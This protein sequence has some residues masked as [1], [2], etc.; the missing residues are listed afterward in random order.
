M[1][2]IYHSLLSM[3]TADGPGVRYVVFLQGCPLRCIYCHNPDTWEVDGGISISVDGLVA[4]ILSVREYLSGGVTISGGEPLLQAKFVTE[5]FT[6]LQAEG[7]HTAL[8]T[9]GCVMNADV[10]NLLAVCD[11]VLLDI[12]M[13]TDENY[14]KY[15]GCKL[16]QVT[17]FLGVV[18]LMNV[19][20]WI[21]QVIV[22]NINDNAEN[23]NKL[24]KLISEYNCIKKVELL[25]FKKLCL[26]KYQALGKQFPLQSTDETSAEMINKLTTLV[27]HY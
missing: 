17:E 14:R 2:G 1:D 27:T 12:K 11:L 16:T 10:V 23:I 26:E 4:K 21:R 13:T 24:N 15:I 22:P 3:G 7:I 5:V 25:P 20:T 6:K 19:P 8:D 9:S 18:D